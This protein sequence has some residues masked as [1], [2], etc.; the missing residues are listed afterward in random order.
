MTTTTVRTQR[1]RYAVHISTA[2]DHAPVGKPHARFSDPLPPVLPPDAFLKELTHMIVKSPDA[3]VSLFYDHLIAKRIPLDGIQQWIKQW[4]YDSR[5]YP[6]VI[7]M[8]AANCSYCM[9]GRQFM[10]TNLAEEL[11]EFNPAKEHPTLV[12]RLAKALG[13]EEDEIEFADPFPETLLYVE[14]RMHLVR[15]FHWLEALA[16]G[17]YAI[18]LTIPGRF[19]KIANALRE[20]FD[21][22]DDALAIFGIHAGDDAL[23]QDY[24]GDVYHAMEAG[25]LIK[26][27]ATT[28]EMQQRIRTAIWRSIEARKVYQWG[29]YREII[30]RKHPVWQTLTAPPA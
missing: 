4:Y 14:Y 12:R 30:L 6:S 5:T 2:L 27:Y 1:D 20:Q 26:K 28:A 29:L 13:V 22:D 19:T 17:S 23:Q 15:H 18:E 8:L 11:G 7:A 9:E 24:G 25:N 10:G 16:A 21:L 3:N